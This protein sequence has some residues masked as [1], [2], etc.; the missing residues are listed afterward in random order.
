MFSIPKFL[1]ITLSFRANIVEMGPAVD[2]EQ[3]SKE[4]W[5]KIS[6]F[7]RMLSTLLILHFNLNVFVCTLYPDLENKSSTESTS[8]YKVFK[9]II[10]CIYF[11]SQVQDLSK[12]EQSQCRSFAL[13]LGPHKIDNDVDN[14]IQKDRHFQNNCL[15]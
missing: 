3:Y 8:D 4:I 12:F 1:T 9:R 14:N 2:V 7:F 15:D 10:S 6:P 11:G 13:A 5:F